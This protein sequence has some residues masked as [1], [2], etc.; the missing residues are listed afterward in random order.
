MYHITSIPKRK[1]TNRKSRHEADKK[2]KHSAVKAGHLQLM[3]IGP[4]FLCSAK[5]SGFHRVCKICAGFQT[6]DD[7]R[8]DDRHVRFGPR[9]E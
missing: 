2:T 3:E 7:H 1:T 9:N 4:F 6:G 8:Y 5:V